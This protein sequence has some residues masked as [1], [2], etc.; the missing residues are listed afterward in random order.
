MK[1]FCTIL[2]LLVFTLSVTAQKQELATD[3]VSR[4]YDSVVLKNRLHK[5][6]IESFEVN[7]ENLGTLKN[8][9]E[10]AQLYFELACKDSSNY[11]ALSRYYLAKVVR[12]I[13][14]NKLGE[15]EY[16]NDLF[17]ELAKKMRSKNDQILAL[18]R[19]IGV[20]SF[21]RDSATFFQYVPLVLPDLENFDKT[22]QSDDFSYLNLKSYFYIVGYLFSYYADVKDTAQMK[23]MYRVV[24]HMASVIDTLDLLRPAE[25]NMF[26]RSLVLAK[27]MYKPFSPQ[28][29]NEDF[30]S[31]IIKYYL[32][33]SASNFRAENYDAARQFASMAANLNDPVLLS[34][35]IDLF[36]KYSLDISLIN[37]D[38]FKS[39]YEGS[40]AYLQ[41][42]YKTA[43]EEFL[44]YALLSTKEQ[45]N[46]KV[47]FVRNEKQNYINLL[48]TN[49]TIAIKDKAVE[50]LNTYTK[51]FILG[52]VLLIVVLIF[53]YLNFARETKRYD[54]DRTYLAQVIHDDIT[55]M[56]F[57]ARAN[58][59]NIMNDGKNSSAS[60]DTLATQLDSLFDHARQLSHSIY[61]NKRYKASVFIGA[62]HQLKDLISLV[63]GKQIILNS[64][65]SNF[66]LSFYQYNRIKM[67]LSEMMMNS[68]KH[69]RCTNI[70][71]YIYVKRRKIFINYK[72]DGMGID[73]MD[74][75]NAGFGTKSLS[76]HAYYLQGK[77]D[78]HNHF[79]RGYHYLITIPII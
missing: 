66:N 54:R 55:P 1:S 48:E 47:N 59:G 76:L 41:K 40:L 64:S 70:N 9:D 43:A 52:I 69:A 51:Y 22:V 77:V 24:N 14:I 5:N 25:K 18:R 42:D 36:K 8:F 32:D 17:Y 2:I 62:I 44:N 35:A 23:K 30:H 27:M 57:L 38:Q 61:A 13:T 11:N 15:A 49:K 21:I 34:K 73:N 16:Y 78:L 71:I 79:P 3:I 26:D 12:K 37:I 75:H 4:Y 56:I 74:I 20:A 53:I 63:T 31:I 33:S 10:V 58:L 28:E 50:E 67:M 65:L 68:V 6:F 60:F 39:G 7:A 29:V 46:A 72:D 45:R 19:Y